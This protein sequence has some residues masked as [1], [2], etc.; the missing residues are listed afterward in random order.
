MERWARCGARALAVGALAIGAVGGMPVLAQG[1]TG[2]ADLGAVKA[3]VVEQ[4]AE[5]K[6]ATEAFRQTAEAYYALA[7]AAGFDY[8]RLWGERPEEV[9]A[10]LAELKDHWLAASTGYELNEG[11]IA[12]VPALSYY[13]VW[14]DAGPSAAEDPAAAL[15]WTLALPDGRKLEQPGNFFHN[16]TEPAV[17]GTDDAFVG[18]RADLDGDGAPETGEALPE[19]NLL[20]ASA[21]GLDDATAEMQAAVAEWEPTIEDVFAALVTMIPTMNEYFEQWKQ[22]SFVAG[23]TSDQAAFVA[24]SR[25]ADVNGILHGLSVAYDDIAPLVAQAD[26]ALHAQ[27]DD[28]FADLVASVGDL[29]GQEA[30]GTRFTPEQADLFGGEAQAKATALVGH[31]SQ[32]IAL[33]GLEV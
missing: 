18:L 26:P 22:S 17:W 19:A 29:Y 7:E 33:L 3:Y 15:D 27:I 28:G 25:L 10:L 16:L 11:L 2:G 8:D 4:A 9:A 23:E 31:V 32:A 5:Q 24:T 21:R 20:V 6:E 1:E 12:G 30:D 13:D 14:I